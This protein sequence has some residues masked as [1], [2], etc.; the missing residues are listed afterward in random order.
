[1]TH[2]MLTIASAALLLTLCG[3]G[4]MASPIPSGERVQAVAAVSRVPSDT[5]HGPVSSPRSERD[6][7]VDFCS[8]GIL[9]NGAPLGTIGPDLVINS[10]TCTVDGTNKPYNFHNV[11]ILGTGSA[12][13]TLTFSDATMD[14]Y[15]ANILVQ[16][17]GVLQA[18][19]IGAGNN[20]NVLTIHLYGGSTGPGVTCQKMDNG[21]LT[22]DNTC[23]VPTVIWTSN[24]GLVMKDMQH[25][26]PKTCLTV[27]QIIPNG[28]LRLPG[29][30]DDCFY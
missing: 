3:C 10:M 28:I 30:V 22:Q 7:A 13:G 6:P 12:T 2:R 14:F 24:L 16:N 23:G 8:G 1:M 27:S 29:G 21:N 5:T 20:G 9:D 19:G 4:G 15:A 18:A 11:Y 17:N 26:Y 25:R